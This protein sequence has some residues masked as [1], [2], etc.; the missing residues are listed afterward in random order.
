MLLFHPTEPARSNLYC[1]A[2][3]DTDGKFEVSTYDAHDGAPEGKYAVTITW[4][5]IN[6]EDGGFGDDRFQG[7][8]NNPQATPFQAKVASPATELTTFEVPQ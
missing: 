4:P 6:V 2:K 5:A 1:Y 8:F 3:T 7:K